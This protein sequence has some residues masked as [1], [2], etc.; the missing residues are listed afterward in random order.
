[1]SEGAEFYSL[2]CMDGQIRQI[3]RFVKCKCGIKADRSQF[4]SLNGRLMCAK[5]VQ[6]ADR[7]SNSNSKRKGNNGQCC[8]KNTD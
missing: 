8:D 3:P 7:Y 5:C 2:L 4:Y 6:R 1:M